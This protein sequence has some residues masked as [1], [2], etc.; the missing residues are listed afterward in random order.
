M[1][2]DAA[3]DAAGIIAANLNW[4]TINITGTLSANRPG[5]LATLA[6]L[7]SR[8]EGNILRSV[9]NTLA[10]GSWY[11]RL[12]IGNLDEQGRSALNKAFVESDIE[13]EHFEITG[14]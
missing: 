11:L 2:L 4:T 12:V 9:N 6:S 3:L 5:V 8:Q 10:N 13:M 14:D 1:D 7:I